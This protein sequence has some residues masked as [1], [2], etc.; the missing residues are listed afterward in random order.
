MLLFLGFNT[1]ARYAT[2]IG[3]K[4]FAINVLVLNVSF[5]TEQVNKDIYQE[6]T[7]TKKRMI[8]LELTRKS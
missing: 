1:F 8:F 6:W 5:K 4:N 3:E 7:F 2:I